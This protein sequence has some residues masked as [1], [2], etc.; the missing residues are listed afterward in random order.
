LE[1]EYPPEPRRDE[2]GN[3]K[4]VRV[5][6]HETWAAMEAAHAAGLV[7]NI[8]VSNFTSQLLLDLLSYCSV[9]PA[10]HQIELHPYLA[11]PRQLA[12]CAR[13]GIAVTAYSSFGAAS[14]VELGVG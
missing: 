4:L 1:E 5:P 11:Q 10:V 8:G 3:V 13:H 7:R 9:R 6:L 2:A 14:Y 12:F